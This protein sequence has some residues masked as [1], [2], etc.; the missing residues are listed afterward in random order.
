MKASRPD[1]NSDRSEAR[2]EFTLRRVNP[3][4]K[5]IG[6]ILLAALLSACPNAA[7]NESKQ[8]QARGDKAVGQKQFETA[9]GEYQK[10]TEKYPDNHLAWYGMGQA[11]AGKGDW[12]KAADSFEQ[13]VQRAD[14]EPMYQQWYG[15]ALYEKAVAA[16]REDQAH[17]EGKKP[18]E[19]DPDLSAVSF[20]KSEQHLQEAIKLNGD[21]WR[22]HYYLGKIYKEQ[23]KAK[24]AANE[25]TAAI[26]ANPYEEGP[27]VAL[28]ELYRAWEYDEE[29]IKIALQGSTLIPGS[30]E[31]SYVWFELGMG[32]D[33]KGDEDKA[34][35]A[36]DKAIEKRKDNHEAKFQRGQAYFRKGDFVHAKHD[37]EEF[38]KS[39]G[40][41]LEFD[42]QQASKMLMDIA[43]KSAG[44][45][46]AG[47]AKQSP[48]DIVKKA[49][50]K[51]G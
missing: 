40:A 35:E 46:G 51:K 34:I 42:K 4:W 13:A 48:E 25:L 7:L 23:N 38:S 24:D 11:Y 19:I 29:A 50:G 41:K 21:L 1:L 18:E 43:M 37:L 12:A 27:Y 32:Y 16:A 15:R 20:D 49:G 45:A 22:S 26:K 30:N 2:T 14:K 9:I 6:P 28:T 44:E 5:A 36:F 10:A 3:S 31:A 47:G 33:E 17:K 39:S 8:A